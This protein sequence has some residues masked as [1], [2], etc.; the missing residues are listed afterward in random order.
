VAEVQDSPTMACCD[1]RG[2]L[3][4]GERRDEIGMRLVLQLT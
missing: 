3:F 1:Y 4:M 2:Q